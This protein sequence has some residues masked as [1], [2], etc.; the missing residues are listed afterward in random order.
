[1]TAKNKSLPY[2]FYSI[3]YKPGWIEKGGDLS[4][5]RYSAEQSLR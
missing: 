4:E 1:M 2:K 5:Q 3:Y